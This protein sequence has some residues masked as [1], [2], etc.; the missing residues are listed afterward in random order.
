[1]MELI[2]IAV[3]GFAPIDSYN[4]GNKLYQDGNYPAAIEAYRNALEKVSSPYLFYNLG[5][6]YFR[7][8]QIGKAIV[9]YR[10]AYFLEPRD[11]DIN[12]NLVYAR[13]YR[14]DKILTGR[15]P[16]ERYLYIFFHWFS[17][18][19]SFWF[20]IV[21]FGL[22]S[23]FISFYILSRK[24]KILIFVF[25]SGFVFFYL[26]LSFSLWQNEKNTL[27]AVVVVPEVSALS[28]PG[29][30][31][32]QIL[33]LHDGTEVLIKDKRNDFVLVQLPGGAGGWLNKEALE[34]IY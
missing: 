14:V 7:N 22:L 24:G 26:L 27:P 6:A 20:S 32:K 1:M 33:L 11:A 31:F 16:I 9:N 8:G 34:K 29:D 13:N 10:R 25:I 4:Q 30:E 18:S 15:G 23:L 2:I 28:G 19:E 21:S 17:N 5:N 12:N 3:L